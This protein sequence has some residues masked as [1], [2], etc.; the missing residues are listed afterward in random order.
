MNK[1]NRKILKIDGVGGT[2]SLR[3][4]YNL[5]IDLKYWDKITL[6]DEN[7]EVAYGLSTDG[8]KQYEIETGNTMNIPVRIGGKRG[9]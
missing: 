2:K 5:E 8:Y 6:Y 4:I 1:L 3:K 9:K 7:E